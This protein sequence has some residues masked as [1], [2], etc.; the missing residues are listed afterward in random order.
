MDHM[1]SSSL[2]DVKALNDDTK[3]AGTDSAGSFKIAIAAT[4]NI[5]ITDMENP[6]EVSEGCDDESIDLEDVNVC[7]ICGDAGQEDKLAICS[8]CSDG[9]EHIYCMRIRLEKVPD[10]DWICEDCVLS[11]LKDD[12]S[13]TRYS[14]FSAT[15][16]HN[17]DE[18]GQEVEA[19]GGSNV[20]VNPI[21]DSK[22]LDID[23]NRREKFS[24]QPSFKRPLGNVQSALLMRRRALGLDNVLTSRQYNKALKS[25]EVSTKSNH[26][27][28]LPKDL[29]GMRQN[30]DVLTLSSQIFPKSQELPTS[31]GLLTKSKSFSSSD[32]RRKVQFLEK[33]PE[34]QKFLRETAVSSKGKSCAFR[35][36]KK[37]LSFN[38]GSSAGRSYTLDTEPKTTTPKHSLVSDTKRL[39]SLKE[40]GSAEMEAKTVLKKPRIFPPGGLSSVSSGEKKFGTRCEPISTIFSGIKCSDIKTSQ[41]LIES[42]TASVDEKKS[43]PKSNP[44]QEQQRN[45]NE[46]TSSSLLSFWRHHGCVSATGQAKVPALERSSHQNQKAPQSSRLN[47]A[48]NCQTEDNSSVSANDREIERDLNRSGGDLAPSPL[49]YHL[50]TDGSLVIP[51][52]DYLWKGEFQVQSN[53]KL[54]GV[55]SRIQA[56]LSTQSSPR[57]P[58]VV[59]NFSG[60]ILLEEVPRSSTWPTQFLKDQPQDDNIGLYFFAQD[61]ESYSKYKSFLQCMIDYDLALRGNFDGI[62]LLIFSSKLLPEKSQCWNKLLFLWGIFK[63]RKFIAT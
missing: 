27:L 53:K 52:F 22:V 49:Y 33:G 23:K 9:A 30:A 35:S 45:K 51:L 40:C 8:K 58:E 11:E 38:D 4:E 54:P 37:S 15:L 36:L 24:G 46:I 20:K 62:E 50:N 16:K 17:K 25:K 41:N 39:R 42:G 26:E 48:M 28:L 55:L 57:I 44:S 61:I 12:R 60:K 7:D 5:T 56:H 43:S 19:S 18:P 10:T 14:N 34:K 47:V 21:S 6:D 29:S 3:E 13:E 1:E 31:S 59:K 63:Q 2:D 32:R